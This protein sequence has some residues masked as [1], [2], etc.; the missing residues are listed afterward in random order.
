MVSPAKLLSNRNLRVTVARLNILELLQH[1]NRLE[2]KDI[3][4]L[5]DRADRGT[6]LATVHRVLV[7]LVDAGLAERHY[8]GNGTASFS[9]RQAS[10]AAHLVCRRCAGVDTV[11]DPALSRLVRTLSQGRGF[12][13]Q[14]AT[15]SLRGICAACREGEDA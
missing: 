5:L 10:P 3:F 15:I 2:P 13:L 12:A 7:E 1:N 14:E 11:E 9:P 4:R 8:I 6:S